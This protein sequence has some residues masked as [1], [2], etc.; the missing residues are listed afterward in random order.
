MK[1][2]LLIAVLTFTT[3][4]TP[5]VNNGVIEGR[6]T[7]VGSSEG[8]SDVQ[9]TLIGPSTVTSSALGGLYTPNTSLTPDMRAQIDQLMNK[10]NK[11]YFNAAMYYMDNG[12]DLNQALAWF[13]KAV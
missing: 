1:Q 12:K 7:R 4:Q 5:Q 3:L 11:P 6:V 13:D 2:L 10:D 9:V 8:I